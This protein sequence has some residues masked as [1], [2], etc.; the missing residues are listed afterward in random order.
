M[1]LKAAPSSSEFINEVLKRWD[2]DFESLSLSYLL[3]NLTSFGC[4]VKWISGN[5]LPMVEDALR[6]GSA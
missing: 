3:H 5:H 1:L 2:A 4:R 6:E